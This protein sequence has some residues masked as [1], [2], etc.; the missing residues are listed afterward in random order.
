MLVK[1]YNHL[2]LIVDGDSDFANQEADKDHGLDIFQLTSSSM[3]TMK[4]IVTRELLEFRRFHVNLKE[5][6]KSSPFVGET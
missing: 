5:I 3:K 2:H 6:K 4:E 1:L